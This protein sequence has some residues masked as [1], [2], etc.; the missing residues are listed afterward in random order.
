MKIFVAAYSG[1]WRVVICCWRVNHPKFSI[2][3]KFLC[4][5]WI[6]NLHELSN[7]NVSG[8]QGPTTLLDTLV[9]MMWRF[10]TQIASLSTQISTLELPHPRKKCCLRCED[11]SAP[12]YLEHIGRAHLSNLCFYMFVH[13]CGAVSLAPLPLGAILYEAWSRRFKRAVNGRRFF[14]KSP[15]IEARVARGDTNGGVDDISNALYFC[16]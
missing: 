8:A 6:G 15:T 14:E 7:V 1:P 3:H 5:L 4:I 9:C 11:C 13:P 2:S 16:S 10:L 12:K